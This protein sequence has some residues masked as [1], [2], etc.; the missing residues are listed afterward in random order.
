MLGT[1]SGYVAYRLATTV[2]HQLRDDL[3]AKPPAA[4]SGGIVRQTAV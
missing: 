1:Q 2:T 3:V 4:P